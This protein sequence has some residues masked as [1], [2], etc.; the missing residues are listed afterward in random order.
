MNEEHNLFYQIICVFKGILRNGQRRIGVL[1][2]GKGEGFIHFPVHEVAFC[3]FFFLFS[4]YRR[5]EGH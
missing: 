5:W 1:G 3:S 2:P 4:V